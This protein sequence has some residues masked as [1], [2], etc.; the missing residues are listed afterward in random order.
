MN[1]NMC[2]FSVRRERTYLQKCTSRK[3]RPKKREELKRSVHFYHVQTRY[4]CE[5][6]FAISARSRTRPT[7]ERP[8]WCVAIA[9]AARSRPPTPIT[10]CTTSSPILFNLREIITDSPPPPSVAP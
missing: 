6:N 8:S 3:L 7:R 9:Q 2:D 5:R 10:T 1:L 4:K